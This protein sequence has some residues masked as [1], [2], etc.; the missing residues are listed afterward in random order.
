MEP[1]AYL[2]TL[3]ALAAVSA[4]AW[5]LVVK[6]WIIA[7]LGSALTVGALAAALLESPW[8]YL[9]SEGLLAFF[10]LSLNAF[11]I[12]MGVGIPF[13]RRRNPIASEFASPL[14]PDP[15]LRLSGRDTIIALTVGAAITYWIFVRK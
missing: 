12:A 14:N 15:S 8:R 9:S 5:H 3:L 13:N 6:R 7:S 11:I 2:G 4:V 1:L 10:F